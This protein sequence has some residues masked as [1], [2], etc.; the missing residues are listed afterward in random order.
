M[1]IKATRISTSSG[2]GAVG[3]HVYDGEDNDKISTLMGDRSML[4][5][6]VE[7]AEAADA[8]YAIRHFVIN[9]GEPINE[10]G[11]KQVIDNI[12]DEFNI[13]QDA[14]ITLVA[15]QKD[16]A[17]GSYNKHFHMMVGEVDP[18]K[19][20]VMESHQMMKRHEAVC[21]LSEF[22]LDHE[23][24]KGRH[25][26][27]V[28]TH[29]AENGHQE[30]AANMKHLQKGGLPQ[31][32]YTTADHQEAKRKGVSKPQLVNMIK[33]A[34]HQSDNAKSFKAALKEKNIEVEP[35]RK[36]G[37]WIASQDGVQQEI[38]RA[39][40]APRKEIDKF[41]SMESKS[42]LDS[43][44]VERGLESIKDNIAAI[45]GDLENA[46]ESRNTTEDTPEHGKPDEPAGPTPDGGAE[47]L[48]DVAG[49]AGNDSHTA[50]ANNADNGQSN[51]RNRGSQSSPVEVSTD[52]TAQTM[53]DVVMQKSGMKSA[54][55]KKQ[56]VSTK[57]PKQKDMTEEYRRYFEAKALEREM[58][59]S[60]ERA[61]HR[62]KLYNQDKQVRQAREITKAIDSGYQ[63]KDYI[64]RMMGELDPKIQDR[65]ADLRVDKNVHD[66][67]DGYDLLNKE[68]QNGK[69]DINEMLQKAEKLQKQAKEA[70]ELTK[71]LHAEACKEWMDSPA[72]S[73]EYKPN[74]SS[75]PARMK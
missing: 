55:K 17:D 33:E 2:S 7:D 5:M 30:A 63:D 21:R 27:F 32:S 22:Q 50:E 61:E 60:R 72:P 49:N 70:E 53:E 14:L 57:M 28:Y 26:K 12:K 29:L 58:L 13:S 40:K 75:G 62:Q 67:P 44:R 34:W 38:S 65:I 71:K 19:G 47:R 45:K 18:V 35:G 1:I 66:I 59:L 37:L 16:K 69:G 73:Y 24:V 54:P 31:A 10:N 20:T 42:N 48:G 9:P 36:K 56:S 25:N 6:M 52:Y 11:L 41:M 51:K 3:A 46:I 8:K 15:H 74:F 68:M 4:D 43:I 39:V 23:L 64:Q